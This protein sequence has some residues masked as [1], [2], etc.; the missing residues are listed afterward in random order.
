MK[1]IGGGPAGTYL[2]SLL[3]KELKVDLYEQ[4]SVIGKPIQ[5]TGIFT[6]EI[7]TFVK[8]DYFIINKTK[9]IRVNGIEFNAPHI[10]VNR[11]KFDQF[12]ATKAQ[13]K[14]A[15][16]HLKHKYQDNTKDK[17]KINNK[18]I[19][20]KYLIGA[21]GPFSKIEKLNFN[22]KNKYIIGHQIRTKTESH[23]DVVDIYLDHGYFAY[24]VPESNKIAR[25][26]LLTQNKSKEQFTKF[27]KQFKHKIIEHQSGFIPLYQQK[28]IKKSNIYLIGDA[29]SQVKASTFGGIIPSFKAAHKLKDSILNNKPY[30]S[31]NKELILN[32]IIYNKLNKMNLN[33]KNN[34]IK[35]ISKSKSI[36]E[37]INRDNITRLSIKLLLNNPRLIKYL[38]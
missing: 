35:D 14:G 30:T 25:I 27:I 16:I 33:K 4:K 2:S 8:E 9:K 38:F 36:I 23:E 37:T 21:D 3:S 17:V 12:L 31:L 5:C 18:L 28:Q 1:I 10:V 19:P 13:Q 15:N 7:K 6:P 24:K 34:L 22:N 26:A 32:K 29:A 11:L 20:F